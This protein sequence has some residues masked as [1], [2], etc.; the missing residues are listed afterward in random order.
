MLTDR[1]ILENKILI[2]LQ[3]LNTK[4]LEGL[5]KLCL[6]QNI[7]PARIVDIVENRIPIQEVGECELYLIYS[8]LQNIVSGL[9]A[10]N[11]FFTASEIDVYSKSKLPE[12]KVK[13]F[14]VVFKNV[15]K[16]KSGQWQL[17]MPIDELM[18]LKQRQTIIYNP[19]TQR[20]LIVIEKG[21]K[22]ITKVDINQK[23]V[24]D[25]MNLM[26]Q[27]MY[28]P[29]HITINMNKDKDTE[30]IFSGNDI[31][32]NDGQLDII[33]GYHNY[34]AATRM[35]A[36]RSDFEYYMPIILTHFDERQAGMYISQEN[37]KNI[38]DTSYT[39]SLDITNIGN[40]VT[41]RINNESEFYLHNKISRQ[42]NGQIDFK[43]LSSIIS[44]YFKDTKQGVEAA[45]LAKSIYK[46]WN[47]LIEILPEL[48]E[49]KYDFKDLLIIINCFKE[50]ID[51]ESCINVLENSSEQ[52]IQ[53]PIK[54]T[55]ETKIN[56]FLKGC[57]LNV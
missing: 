23:S 16:I 21:E 2:I 4:E 48:Q 53:P 47:D 31:I 13:K 26:S 10:T 25:I 20:P 51:I 32:I 50:N 40:I 35:K 9:T 17:V 57:G 36:Q 44:Y 43:Y 3:K 29:H 54:K 11:K 56:N 45:K 8:N 5:Q 22:I 27:G 49:R 30:P 6:K 19:H 34:V 33:D 38:I 41:D 1:N 52:N 15:Q 42:L 14:P 39:A 24:K 46:Y 18:E 28:N 7:N 37:K 55:V 12:L